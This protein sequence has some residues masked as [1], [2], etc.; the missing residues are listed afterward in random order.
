MA[1]IKNHKITASLSKAIDYA[2]GDK[3]GDIKN[4]K[5]VAD[6]IAYAVNDKTGKIIYKTVSSTLNCWTQKPYDEFMEVIR[7][8]GQEELKNGNRRSKDGKPVLAWHWHQNFEGIVDPVMANEIGRR[9]AEEVFGS[10]KAVIGTHTNTANTHNHIIVCAWDNG[11]RKWNNHNAMYRHIREAS[12]RLCEEYG[13]P[14]LTGTRKQRLVRWTDKDG[15]VHY[16]E[17]TAR[18]NELLRQREKGNISGDSV[19]SYRNTIPYGAYENKKESNRD[20]VRRDIDRLLPS[21]KSYGHLI[22]MMRQIGYSVNDK[23]KNGDWRAHVTFKPPAADKGVR[24]YKIADDGFYARE[25]LERVI[26]ESAQGRD[27]RAGAEKSELRYFDKYVYGEIAL[28]EVDDEY[29]KAVSNDG[30]YK[31][32]E[33]GEAERKIIRYAKAK[34]SELCRLVDTAEL[35]RIIEEQRRMKGRH[36][37]KKR[38]ELLVRQIQESLQAL[39]YMEKEGLYTQ[40]QIDAL[41]ERTMA[42]YGDCMRALG[43]LESTISHLENAVKAQGIVGME[44]RERRSAEE[45]I[46]QS[47]L[48]ME[49]MQSLL[50]AYAKRLEEYDWCARITSRIDKELGNGSGEGINEYREVKERGEREYNKAHKV[51]NNKKDSER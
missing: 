36:V 44:E 1:T 19:G 18:K 28:A 42:K 4:L 47:R 38:E 46:R 20:A 16:Y 41:A 39:R 13:L 21:A 6:S 48:K 45:K 27:V 2:L 10:H 32:V 9:L 8:Y 3:A 51:R 11:G 49:H 12:D 33:R 25:N 40:R 26:L 24:D 15:R 5:G 50:K 22:Q 37:P 35:D 43:R 14:V 30:A 29:R 34:D 17:P 31:I 23:K 7:K